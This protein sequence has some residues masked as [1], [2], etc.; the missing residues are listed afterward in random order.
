MTLQKN[1]TLNIIGLAA[2]MIAMAAFPA[3]AQ[4]N[5]ETTADAQN[6]AVQNSDAQ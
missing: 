4:E 2:A 3:Q 5:T 1:S 6:T